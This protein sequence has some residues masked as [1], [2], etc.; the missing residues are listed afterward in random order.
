LK[1]NQVE[2]QFC[3]RVPFFNALFLMEYQKIKV[4]IRT[5]ATKRT[6]ASS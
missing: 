2:P 4:G 5:D 6:H 3:K 1:N